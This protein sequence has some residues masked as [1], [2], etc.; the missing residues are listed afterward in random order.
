MSTSTAKVQLSSPDPI[1]AVA[2]IMIAWQESA[3]VLGRVAADVDRRL[4]TASGP[5]L[6]P[7]THHYLDPGSRLRPRL[8]LAVGLAA[9][10]EVDRLVPLASA[11]D[12][13]H[14]ASLVHDDVEDGDRFRRGREAVWSH[15]APE[16]AINLGDWLVAQSF[17]AATEADPRLAADLA[18][19]MAATAE[20]QAGDLAGR[21]RGELTF[22]EYERI[23]RAKSGPLLA[24]PVIGALRLSGRHFDLHDVESAAADLGLAYQIFDDVKDLDAL[25]RREASGQDLRE[26]KP[27][28]PVLAFLAEADELAASR[29]REFLA[30]ARARDDS[31]AIAGWVGRL[32]A[33]G[34][35]EVALGAAR[36]ALDRAFARLH[37]LPDIAAL[38]RI[39]LSSLLRGPEVSAAREETR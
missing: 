36:H 25:K 16:I 18:R 32:R 24:F 13:I 22:A 38:L 27:S 5:L 10:V 1:G 20:G 31:E 37:G 14:N 29:L 19:A 15:Y 9:N 8:A 7:A 26:G 39:A 2:S 28:A 12:L 17:C 11:A 3:Y 30:D 21:G 6:S 33:S 34:A 35:R 23:A 4:Q